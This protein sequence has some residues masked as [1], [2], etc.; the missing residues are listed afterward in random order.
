MQPNGYRLTPVR[1]G[2]G[3]G[4]GPRPGSA[5]DR[6]SDSEWPVRASGGHWGPYS[7]E[8]RLDFGSLDQLKTTF[9]SEEIEG[10]AEQEISG[11]WKENCP[12]LG[13]SFAV[14][15]DWRPK[16]LFSFDLLKPGREPAAHPFLGTH[17]DS[18]VAEYPSMCSGSGLGAGAAGLSTGS[19]RRP[20]LI[21]IP[22][23]VLLLPWTGEQTGHT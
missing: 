10:P 1:M 16:I 3:Q 22:P 20:Y 8:A 2:W 13:L 19:L 14:R 23:P 7:S 12:T 18:L 17:G 21:L 9:F 4:V 5:P 6:C 15:L 11:G